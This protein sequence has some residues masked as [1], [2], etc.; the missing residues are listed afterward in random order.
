MPSGKI[1]AGISTAA[2]LGLLGWGMATHQPEMIS[3]ALASGCLVGLFI[4]PDL[5]ANEPTN[6]YTILKDQAGMLPARLWYTLWLPY[7]RLVRHRSWVSH[8][9]VIGTSIRVAYLG[10][11]AW[12]IL[13]V[14]GRPW[15]WAQVPAWVPWVLVGLA[16]SDLLHWAADISWTRVHHFFHHRR[17]KLR[18]F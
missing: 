3:G 9:P 13:L 5:D 16:I 7:S 15:P 6:S 10:L 4:S 17:R 18:L 8:F 2:A 1:H 11:I 12:L 14:L